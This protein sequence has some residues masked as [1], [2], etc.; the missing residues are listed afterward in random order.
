[1]IRFGT[2]RA[3]GLEEILLIVAGMV[4]LFLLCALIMFPGGR[5]DRLE[6]PP[7]AAGEPLLDPRKNG[8]GTFYPWIPIA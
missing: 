3:E 5:P 4:V 1:M 7:M 6:E 2:P 8:R